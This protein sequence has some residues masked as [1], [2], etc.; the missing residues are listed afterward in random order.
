MW[1]EHSICIFVFICAISG[2]KKYIKNG[3][4]INGSLLYI[5]YPYTFLYPPTFRRDLPFSVPLSSI[6]LSL[7]FTSIFQKLDTVPLPQIIV[8]SSLI[9]LS[10][11]CYE[12][13]LA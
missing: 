5:L 7:I 4:N 12:S 8:K 10:V 9:N 13:S 1:H 11:T 6:K 2:L 3:N